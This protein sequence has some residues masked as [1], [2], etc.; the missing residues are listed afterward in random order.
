MRTATAEAAVPSPVK[1]AFWLALA[2]VA[3]GLARSVLDLVYV[4]GGDVDRALSDAGADN[5]TLRRATLAFAGVALMIELL[6]IFRMRAGKRWARAL[7]TILVV[8]QLIGYWVVIGHP[9]EDADSKAATVDL[10]ANSASVSLGLMAA[11]LLYNKGSRA[12][13]GSRNT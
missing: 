2:A 3:V 7:F 6:I 13:F 4:S 12:W 11:I 10:Y 5:E 1:A 8:V 9:V